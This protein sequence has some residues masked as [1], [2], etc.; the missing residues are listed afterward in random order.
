[1]A[2]RIMDETAQ[3]EEQQQQQ[4]GEGTKRQ[5]EGEADVG[6]LVHV[7]TKGGVLLRRDDA[8]GHRMSIATTVTESS[9]GGGNNNNLLMEHQFESIRHLMDESEDAKT[10][11]QWSER[12]QSHLHNKFLRGPTYATK[13]G[14][15][16]E[17]LGGSNPRLGRSLTAEDI[18]MS[19][20]EL[21]ASAPS[22]ANNN[23]KSPMVVNNKNRRCSHQSHDSSVFGESGGIEDIMNMSSM[24]LSD[25]DVRDVFSVFRSATGISRSKSTEGVNRRGNGQATIQQQKDSAKEE[26]EGTK[27]RRKTSNTDAK[28]SSPSENEA[29]LARQVEW[30]RERFKEKLL[31]KQSSS[32]ISNADNN[33]NIKSS[34][35]AIVPPSISLQKP[36]KLRRAST[37]ESSATRKGRGTRALSL[38]IKSNTREHAA[39][40]DDGT[41]LSDLFDHDDEDFFD[42]KAGGKKKPITTVTSIS[43][44]EDTMEKAT[45][46]RAMSMAESKA[47]YTS[48]RTNKSEASRSTRSTVSN[49]SHRVER[50]GSSVR[51]ERTIGLHAHD[52]GSNHSKS[53]RSER[54]ASHRSERSASHR[55]ERTRGE[56]SVVTHATSTTGSASMRSHRTTGS[57][58][59]MENKHLVIDNFENSF[60]LKDGDFDFAGDERE[61]NSGEPNDERGASKNIFEESFTSKA[62]K[63]LTKM[64][65][66]SF[67][68]DALMTPPKKKGKGNNLSLPNL[69]IIDT[70]TLL[71]H[72]QSL[73]ST[74]EELSRV[75]WDDGKSTASGNS[76]EISGEKAGKP[77]RRTSLPT[78][79]SHGGIASVASF[80]SSVKNIF[81]SP[82]TPKR[83][84]KS[85]PPQP[86]ST[87]RRNPTTPRGGARRSRRRASTSAELQ[88]SLAE[89]RKDMGIPPKDVEKADAEAEATE[90]QWRRASKTSPK[91]DPSISAGEEEMIAA[92]AKKMGLAPPPADTQ[93]PRRRASVA[94]P[95]VMVQ[96]EQHQAQVE[97][98]RMRRR[99][100]HRVT[101]TNSDKNLTKRASKRASGSAEPSQTSTIVWQRRSSANAKIIESQAQSQ[102]SFPKSDVA[103]AEEMLVSPRRAEKAKKMLSS[104]EIAEILASATPRSNGNAVDPWPSTEVVAE[105]EI[106]SSDRMV[107]TKPGIVKRS[108][109]H[110]GIATKTGAAL[111]R[112]GTDAGTFRPSEF[113][114]EEARTFSTRSVTPNTA[115]RLRRQTIHIE[116]SLVAPKTPSNRKERLTLKVNPEVNTASG[117]SPNPVDEVDATQNP[118]KTPSSRKDRVRTRTSPE[119]HPGRADGKATAS[120]FVSRN[121]KHM[122]ADETQSRTTPSSLRRIARARRQESGDDEVTK[123]ENTGMATSSRTIHSDDSSLAPTPK[124]QAPPSLPAD[125]GRV[126]V[127]MEQSKLQRNKSQDT[128]K[129]SGEGEGFVTPSKSTSSRRNSRNRRHTAHEALKKTEMAAILSPG[130]FEK[131]KVSNIASLRESTAISKASLLLSPEKADKAKRTIDQKLV[132]EL[133]RSPNKPNRL[134]RRSVT[135]DVTATVTPAKTESAESAKSPKGLNKCRR[136]KSDEVDDVKSGRKGTY[137]RRKTELVEVEAQTPIRSRLR[138]AKTSEGNVRKKSGDG[139]ND[140][141]GR[142]T[143]ATEMEADNGGALDHGNPE[144]RNA[145]TGLLNEL[146]F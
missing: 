132:A 72:S 11:G 116:S 71:E 143:N 133:C 59:A 47:L 7:V 126:P 31:G 96:Q 67:G 112:A 87:T 92:A 13:K 124:P 86:Q 119:D 84:T 100:S 138:R 32:P 16:S 128:P 113:T 118:P 144:K 134:R 68:V 95:P 120:P 19:R 136:S 30:R 55:S 14:D 141:S 46:M 5:D 70:P 60:Q 117:V 101:N 78:G 40:D 45:R 109:T 17:G 111:K 88:A 89:I 122:G 44:L 137:R 73:L 8:K 51:S 130:A 145:N 18:T 75:S 142:N 62:D 42:Q 65:H 127:N 79:S 53:H 135:E 125:H 93:N 28:A 76:I 21:F 83:R 27:Y 107:L 37:A 9:S 63:D 129:V 66:Q 23:S 43:T 24:D 38:A 34:S 121:R 99:V 108:A 94:A 139:D 123:T 61:M 82:K 57:F 146:A 77:K 15:P 26:A 50:K 52:S 10:A 103:G 105:N 98:I 35:D 25:G 48:T 39:H 104:Q 22:S 81:K 64:F 85:P 69:G 2:N 110:D 33:D 115:R 41:V 3:Q 91:A 140:D 74:V 54:S 80:S 56:R 58:G 6:P 4:Q 102:Q 114:I 49:R 1:M 29:A 12:L 20:E 36:L 106:A 97:K 131:P 90:I